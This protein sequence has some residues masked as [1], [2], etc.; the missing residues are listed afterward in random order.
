MPTGLRQRPPRGTRSAALT[1]LGMRDGPSPFGG[2]GRAPLSQQASLQLGSSAP[3]AR[4]GLAGLVRAGR[5]RSA[6]AAPAGPALRAPVPDRHHRCLALGRSLAVA[7][8]RPSVQNLDF[9]ARSARTPN[10][11]SWPIPLAGCSPAARPRPGWPRRRRLC[12]QP[13]RRWRDR[14]ARQHWPESLGGRD[15]R[16]GGRVRLQ[17]PA[18]RAQPGAPASS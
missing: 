12:A 18:L 9:A 16:I 2:G 15:H 5:R 4:A 6:R 1:L 13:I 11:S 3:P 8:R 17:R 7:A 14:A 10:I